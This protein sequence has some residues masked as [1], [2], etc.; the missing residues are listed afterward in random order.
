MTARTL[1]AALMLMAGY[2]APSEAA[3]FTYYGAP[4]CGEWIKTPSPHHKAWLM[5]FMSGVN[6]Q[7][8]FKNTGKDPLAT[9]SSAHQMFGWMDNYCKANPLKTAADVGLVFFNELIVADR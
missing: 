7:F 1:V 4:D 6:A 2:I 8:S 9:L 3:R 5:G